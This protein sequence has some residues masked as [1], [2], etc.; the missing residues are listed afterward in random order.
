VDSRHGRHARIA[1]RRRRPYQTITAQP[2]ERRPAASATVRVSVPSAR[3][4]R[5]GPASP[6][7]CRSAGQPQL[8]Q[9]AIAVRLSVG[10]WGAWRGA[11]LACR[12]VCSTAFRTDIHVGLIAGLTS[13][14][15]SM[16]L[17]AH[18]GSSGTLGQ[19][20]QDCPRD[21][22]LYG[23]RSRGLASSDLYCRGVPPSRLGSPTRL[24]ARPLAVRRSKTPTSA[25]SSAKLGWCTSSA[26]LVRP[27]DSGSA[28][29]Q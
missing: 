25:V 13:E 22:L 4:A 16:F 10:G 2:L 19:H 11:R 5:A 17:G 18:C 7:G 27:N 8:V 14:L 23:V 15:R 20:L 9:D 29:Q 6:S 1:R 3:R 26:M 24:P 21:A 28:F 12:R